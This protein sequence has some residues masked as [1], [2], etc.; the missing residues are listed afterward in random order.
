VT[1]P[2][3]VALDFDGVLC[4][5]RPE[6]FETARR[7]YATAWPGARPVGDAAAAAFAVYRPLVES[8]WEMP[9]LLHAVVSGE[10]AAALVD[11]TAWLVTARRLLGAAGVQPDALA[12][13]LNAVRDVWFARDPGDWVRYH[14]FYPGVAARL[15]ATLDAGTPLAIVTTKAERFARALLA[16]QDARLASLPVVG[17]EPGRVVPKAETLARLAAE[18]ALPPGADGLWFVEDLLETLHTAHATP[19]LG[20]ARLFLAA[21]GYNTLEQRASV[22]ACNDIRLLSLA[23]FGGAFGGWVA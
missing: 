8:G 3:I 23:A 16:A 19:G 2:V 5:G 7:A 18:H 14:T 11:R 12:G 15:L 4:D 17:R 1:Q 9:V 22:G 20:A 21:W 13:A 10:P 6:Y